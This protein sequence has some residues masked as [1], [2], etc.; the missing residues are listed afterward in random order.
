MKYKVLF[1]V[2]VLFAADIVQAQDYIDEIKSVYS[3]VDSS[4]YL[5]KIES[6]DI[7]RYCSHETVSKCK[8][9]QGDRTLILKVNL[10]WDEYVA[11]RII[12]FNPSNDKYPFDIYL[13]DKKKVRYF[14]LMDESG[15]FDIN[16]RYVTLAK[17]YHR[18]ISKA[19][20]RIMSINPDYILDWNYLGSYLYI[21]NDVM[22]VYSIVDNRSFLLTDYI[23]N[24]YNELNA[25]WHLYKSIL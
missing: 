6:L 14:I 17:G 9:F 25:D 10:N 13:F 23:K 3:S 8:N 1:V 2:C 11:D 24:N 16:E 5:N 4:Q 15:I 12:G 22:Y 7:P 19:L 20:K 21:K 18:K